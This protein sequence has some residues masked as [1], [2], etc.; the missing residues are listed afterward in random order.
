MM[1]ISLV[2][3]FF[4]FWALKKPLWKSV[5]RCKLVNFYNWQQRLFLAACDYSRKQ[6]PAFLAAMINFITV[7]LDIICEET[8]CVRL[9]ILLIFCLLS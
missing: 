8:Y 5:S 1:V 4:Q 7:I 3:S 2:K 6:I 9:M